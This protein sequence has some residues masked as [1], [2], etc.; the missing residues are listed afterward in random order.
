MSGQTSPES[1]RNWM[2]EQFA[3]SSIDFVYFLLVPATFYLLGQAANTKVDPSLVI[4]SLWIF[5]GALL[6]LPIG[7]Y[8]KLV[9][10]IKC[11]IVAWTVYLVISSW[12]FAFVSLWYIA[13]GLLIR[14][15]PT[16]TFS[17]TIGY[18][19]LTMGSISSAGALSS[20]LLKCIVKLFA[21]RVP[22]EEKGIKTTFD[23]RLLRERWN[24]IVED[25]F[26]P[27]KGDLFAGLALYLVSLYCIAEQPI[28]RDLVGIT[29]TIVPFLVIYP[30]AW[31]ISGYRWRDITKFVAELSFTFA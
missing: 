11:R 4:L 6:S 22:S 31:Y 8:A 10:S 30:V 12:I 25:D 5:P 16:D 29:W 28:I 13:F 3:L 19:Y 21:R 17:S 18:L 20:L 9:D 2:A 26:K 14:N 23:V 24:R 1:L 27:D 15:S 7:I